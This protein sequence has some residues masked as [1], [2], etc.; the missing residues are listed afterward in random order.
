MNI[1]CQ[2]KL[3]FQY[4]IDQEIL[5]CPYCY[6]T[7]NFNNSK[8]RSAFVSTLHSS[9]T[10]IDL[11][12]IPFR[13]IKC[14]INT[15]GY[16]FR[17]TETETT[18]VPNQEQSVVIMELYQQLLITSQSEFIQYLFL[19]EGQ[20]GTGK[21]STIM[22]L[23]KYPEFNSFKICFSAPTNKAIQ[24]MMDKLNDND[25]D[26]NHLHEDSDMDD[27]GET[28]RIFETVF[29]LTNSKTSI[30]SIGETLFEYTE[31]SDFQF[32]Y[33]I[34]VIDEVSMIEK[35]QLEN[36][37]SSVKKMKKDEFMGC[38]VPTIIFMGDI[39]QLPPVKD[40]SSIIFDT[41]IQQQYAIRKMIL[42]QIMR[43]Q[44]RLTE[45]SQNVRQLIPFSLERIIEH[46]LAI[47]DLKKFGCQQI[48][49]SANR[50]QW[51]T[52]YKTVFQR[53][54]DDQQTNKNNIA[55]IILVYTNAECETLNRE[56]R[57]LIFNHPSDQFVKG[58]LLVFKGYY[59]LK[60]QRITPGTSTKSAYFVKYFTS[61]PIIVENV[62]QTT[63]I[64][65]PFSYSWIFGSID[66]LLLQIPTWIQRKVSHQQY[67]YIAAELSNIL[68][69]W[70]IDAQN[71]QIITNNQVID[72][73]LNKI[74]TLINKLNH[75]YAINYLSIDGKSKLD[76]NDVSS[77]DVFITVIS[78][79]SMNDYL[80]NCDKIKTLIKTHYQTLNM[81]YKNNR[82]MKLLIDYIFQKIWHNYY[83]RTYLWP[84]ANITYGYAITSH[85][86][87]G[88]TY[89]NTFV[90]ISNILGCQKVNEIVR[91]KSLYTSMT[92]AAKSINILYHKQTILPLVSS[93][94][95]FK[96]L[97]CYQL[98]DSTM[99]PPTNY[100]IDKV[101]AEKLLGQ[102]KVMY[103]YTL[104]E[105]VILS[106][107]NK[108]LYQIPVSE[109][110]DQHINEAYNYI[111]SNKLQRSEVDRYQYSNLMLTK[112]II[113]QSKL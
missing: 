100:T 29:K 38:H 13:C 110:S 58:E 91:A 17:L 45:L 81:L 48:K 96:C 93:K 80:A 74:T 84:F 62:M 90:N 49:Y 23:F 87:Q 31:A 88:S 75:T 19:L 5:T 35:N 72:T 51:L 106:D 52:D 64:I 94:M 11:P 41:K 44:D 105:Y 53:N 42:T 22:H 4:D 76:P 104:D 67:E 98:Y 39:G 7:Y 27:D 50:E 92:R 101:C 24:V 73:Q 112:K 63:Q 59:C 97:L 1:N 82:T 25:D 85:K 107:K 54:L 103:L 78:D 16:Q 77:E 55:P 109:L 89:Q 113:S 21:T 12:M 60:R 66:Y 34:I 26:N 3:L 28:D 111:I 86:S 70:I 61:E 83:Y 68:S 43:S 36:I 37:F 56:C 9:Q 30:N 65:T 33:D 47:V 2:Q 40:D 46:D 18:F 79:Q 6:T 32:K 14:A 15:D 95:K 8:L 10:D 57:N 71:N 108:N 99:F 20:A 102:I 69:K